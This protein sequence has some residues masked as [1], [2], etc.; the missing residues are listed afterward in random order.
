M[1]DFNYI[2]SL[3]ELPFN[4][5]AGGAYKVTRTW[6]ASRRFNPNGESLTIFILSTGHLKVSQDAEWGDNSVIWVMGEMMIDGKMIL[7][8]GSSLNI[9]EMGFISSVTSGN[10][11]TLT[12]ITPT[13]ASPD[14][15]P[16]TFSAPRKHVFS[17]DVEVTGIWDIPAA[18]PEW[19]TSLKP[20]SS[21][22]YNG[23]K[24]GENN[25]FT[26][27]DNDSDWSPAINKAI[28]MK[29]SG[30]VSLDRGCYRIR[31]VI[32]MNAGI[33]L[34]GACGVNFHHVKSDRGSSVI[35][36]NSSSTGIYDDF[37]IYLNIKKDGSGNL[38][39]NNT[40]LTYLQS[41]TSIENIFFKTDT[42]HLA[43]CI[44]AAC[45][46]HFNNLTF[47]N[48]TQC[49][50]YTSHYCDGRRITNCNIEDNFKKS[51]LPES[52]N[53]DIYE[54]ELYSNG[55]GC[56]IEGVGVSSKVFKAMKI[57]NSCGTVITG[58]IIN[59]PVLI[60]N[61]KAVVFS[62]NH[63]ECSGEFNQ[64]KDT[65]LAIENSVVTVEGNFFEKSSVPSIVIANYDW[66]TEEGVTSRADYGTTSVVT[67]I[68][69][70]FVY[71]TGKQYSYDLTQWT[72]QEIIEDIKK[73]V[74]ETS[75]YDIVTD[76]KGV[77][78]LMSNFRYAVTDNSSVASNMFPFGIKI[79]LIKGLEPLDEENRPKSLEEFN[80]LSFKL[81]Q[82]CLITY[83]KVVTQAV[84]L[85]E[86]GNNLSYLYAVGSF[87]WLSE[88]GTYSYEYCIYP[89]GIAPSN[90]NFIKMPGSIALSDNNKGIM[91]SVNFANSGGRGR[92]KL[93]RTGPT[94]S[95]VKTVILPICGARY[96][97]D[98]GIAIAGFKWQPE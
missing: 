91:M 98:N 23:E 26:Y 73:R 72:F 16:C 74:E 10:K 63:L 57:G 29:A 21:S 44:L 36:F 40:D 33:Q 25:E 14:V 90:E 6:S 34:R 67:A 79:G 41:G 68:N 12:T 93:R 22:Y 64:N 76:G 82:Q 95:T 38:V 47:R 89:D 31:N 58:C 20:L 62:G 3:E 30:E 2:N 61:A 28:I 81:S 17:D 85:S 7:G 88:P 55:D 75:D 96:L 78:S 54:I 52:F 18:Y 87:Y 11:A 48:F 71:N 35:L 43:K 50:K 39:L 83:N 51:D 1:I 69:N 80:N 59:S 24:Y 94:S 84:S 4:P 8:S 45:P 9:G 97:Y 42:S 15:S 70:Q 92:V 53:S 56:V 65:H 66:K 60:R 49:I 27:P 5:V 19:F 37:I 77:L 13:N 86:S 46:C 32:N